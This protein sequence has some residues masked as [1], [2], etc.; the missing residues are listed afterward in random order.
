LKCRFGSVFVTASAFVDANRVE[1]VAPARA[2]DVSS[3]SL[4]RRRAAQ[5]APVAVA[6]NGRDFSAAAVGSG[7][8]GVSLYDR[9][10]EEA[11]ASKTHAH[12]GIEASFSYGAKLEIFSLEPTRGPAS[13]GTDVF[14]R[15]AYFL[16]PFGDANAGDANALVPS[17]VSSSEG[18][19]GVPSLLLSPEGERLDRF[20]FFGC[21]FDQTLVPASAGSVTASSAS[22]RSP[23][24]AAGFVAVEVR[25]GVAGNF[26]VFGTTFEFQAPPRAETLFPPVGAAGGGTLVSVAGANFV[27]S[28]GGDS[29]GAPVTGASAATPSGAFASSPLRCRFGGG[30]ESAASFISSAVLRCET[31]AFAASAVDRA[32]PVDVSLNGGKDFSSGTSRVAFEPLASPLVL[33]LEPRAGTAGGGTVVRVFGRGF[34]ADAPVWCKFGTTG[35]I[36]AEYASEGAVRCK[37]PAKA[38]ASKIPVEVSR[39]NTVDL[40]TD[41]VLFSV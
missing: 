38:T 10:H 14:V 19:L 35:P 11:T 7:A 15:G 9:H 30:A 8:P 13:G 3:L 26:T 5:V 40:T 12:A 31:P 18:S 29:F 37:S 22:C 33:S 1:C 34:T 27:D 25:A 16:G 28:G 2:P 6:V 17:S 32:L 20:F 41:A 39:G 24:H 4:D 21:K 23:P 36:P